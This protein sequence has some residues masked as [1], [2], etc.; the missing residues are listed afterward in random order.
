MHKN[1]S[2]AFTLVSLMLLLIVFALS[3][4]SMKEPDIIAESSGKFSA[5]SVLQRLAEILPG[6]NQPHPVNSS[7]NKVFRNNI[8]R[9][10]HD[11]GLETEIQSTMSCS[12]GMRSI[13]CAKV[14]NIISQIRGTD[15]A[16][17]ILLVA[18]YDS[19]AAGPGAA[20]AGHAVATILELLELLKPQ[21]PFKNDLI[22]LINEGEEQG[23]LGAEAFM[24][25]HPL[26]K[27]VD[28]VVNMEARGNQGKSLLFETGDNNYRLMKLFQQSAEK[29]SSNSLAYEIYKLLPNDTDLNVFKR[30]GKTGINFA[31]QGRVSHYHTPLDNL[32]NLSAGSVQHQG[33]NVYAILKPLLDIDLQSLPEG[34]AVYTD[35]LSRFMIVWPEH[36]TTPLTFFAAFLS[37]LICWQLIVSKKITANQLLIAIP[38]AVSVVAVSALSCWLILFVVQ[39]VSG[40][41]Q[42]WLSQP[43]PMR[44]AVW[45]FPFSACIYFAGKYKDKLEF[46]GLI[47]ACVF[48]LLIL[49][50]VAGSHLP[51]LSYLFLIPL[52]SLNILLS[53]IFISGKMN[54]TLLISAAVLFGALLMAVLIFP[55]L[56]ILE[57]VMGFSIAPVFGLLNSLVI[58]L[59]LPTI[60]FTNQ[61]TLKYLTR[62]IFVISLIGMTISTQQNAFS[63][64]NP[65]HINFEYLQQGDKATIQTLTRYLLPDNITAE[66]AFSNNY[67]RSRPWSLA[68]YPSIETESI[69]LPVPELEVVSMT[70]FEDE[71]QMTARYTSKRETNQF[72]L[73]SMNDSRLNTLSFEG[74]SNSFNIPSAFDSQY[75][76]C[77]GIEC[78]G[79]IFSIT[80]TGDEPLKLGLVDYSY[81]L[82]ESLSYLLQT[83]GL[84]AQPIQDGDVTLVHTDINLQIETA[85]SEK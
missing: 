74:G 12:N 8:V 72:L 28:V 36:L 43:I 29:P 78:N 41:P 1:P 60:I 85:D 59:V 9:Q 31:F 25:E 3:S 75:L 83:R 33:D 52:L 46:W 73:Y 58:L 14:N 38:F 76:I 20:D 34:N 50:F 45:L 66:S 77:I 30:Y 19:V 64:Q 37:L 67:K 70:R 51:G 6:N 68:E 4:N 18:H 24:K 11:M 54:E 15:S 63:S 48:L 49:S 61:T 5:Q 35:I 2:Q 65:Q 21:T 27:E 26:A 42:P 17:T 84:K 56:L 16:T 32:Q 39:S 79:Q 44:F 80:F 40:Q 82:P 13:R 81:G 7:A 69:D 22:V 57:N 62:T 53:L 55:T 71:W 10:L 23:L 47:L